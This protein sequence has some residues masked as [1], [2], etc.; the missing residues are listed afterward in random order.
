VLVALLQIECLCEGEGVMLTD[1]RS[2]TVPMPPL[3]EEEG[4]MVASR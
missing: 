2:D 4:E 3:F 1:T